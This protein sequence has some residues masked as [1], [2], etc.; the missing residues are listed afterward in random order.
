MQ[1][2]DSILIEL[3]AREVIDR[4]RGGELRAEELVSVLLERQRRLSS[5]NALSWIDEQRALQD[6]REVDRKRARGERLG[7]LAGLPLLIKDNIAVAGSPNAA[8]T[9]S[10]R[11]QIATKNAS[12]VQRLLDQDALA[13][14]RAN[15][16]ELAG[17]GTSSNPTFGPVGNPYDPKRVPGGSSGGTAAALAARLA[18]AGLGS[19]TAGSVR[20]PSA[21]SGTVGLRPTI[22]PEKLYPD[23]GVVPL[24]LDLDTVG[25]MARS[26][27]DVA[28]LH[29]V[30]SA[31]PVP[32]APTAASLR[33]GIPRKPYWE[34]LETEV[35]QVAEQAL[36]RL[37]AAGVILVD[38]DVGAYYPLAQEIYMTLVTHGIKA[39]LQPYLA[40]VDV[41]LS[42]QELIERIAS[43]DTKTLFEDCARTQ[44]APT[45]LAKARGALREK[46]QQVYRNLFSAHHIVAIAFPTSPIV[47]PLINP[48]G[49]RRD[50]QID[51]NGRRVNLGQTMFRNTRVT[52]ALGAP[53]LS[54]PAGLT[55][56][57][58]PVGLELDGLN[59]ADADLLAVGM[60][61]EQVL[62]ALP[63]PDI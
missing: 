61:V 49:D 62:G 21:L 38:V 39:D 44:I 56:Q 1:Q 31:M 26:V 32:T 29:A 37:R 36:E 57:G 48:N 51:L 8:G 19:D 17:G 63:A 54:L 30:I 27:A 59:G 60:R 3:S 42:V 16:H 18:P 58:L 53:G 35:A 20:I 33:I 28:L 2:P 25:P 12:V 45:T 13:F 15:M 5:L 6:A 55:R 46:I 22:R 9:P 24:A 41:T 47:A 52:G 7:T 23:E 4:V 10:L 11:D 34:D 43:R 40:R 50:A 14:A